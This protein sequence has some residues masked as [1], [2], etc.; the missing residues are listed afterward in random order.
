MAQ[1]AGLFPFGQTPLA[2]QGGTKSASEV[3]QRPNP[4]LIT[5]CLGK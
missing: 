4:E 2:Q 1:R 5:L 3:Y